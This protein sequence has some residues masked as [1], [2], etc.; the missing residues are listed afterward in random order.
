MMN[1]LDPKVVDLAVEG[2]VFNAPEIDEEFEALR[3]RD[4][5]ESVA[6]DFAKEALE[7]EK[8][9]DFAFEQLTGEKLEEGEMAFEVEGEIDNLDLSIDEAI[10]KGKDFD[11]DLTFLNE[12]SVPN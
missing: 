2:I 8:A 3:A 7:L 1:V 9:L 4:I 12:V 10:L 5:A 6:S 11:L